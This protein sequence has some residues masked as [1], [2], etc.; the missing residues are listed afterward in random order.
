MQILPER[1]NVER[2]ELY[3]II[4]LRIQSVVMDKFI[5]QI[6]FCDELSLC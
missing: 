1:V 6:P 5:V 4:N 2:E 3:V